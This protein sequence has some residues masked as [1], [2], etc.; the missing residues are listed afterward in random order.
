[1]LPGSSSNC[2]HG[3][4]NSLGCAGEGG[5]GGTGGVSAHA[6][7]RASHSL[8]QP[9]NHPGQLPN[10][11]VCSPPRLCENALRERLGM[12]KLAGAQAVMA[13]MSGATP[14]IAIIRFRL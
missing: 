5:S 9:R 1:L 8:G 3:D 13:W 2:L 12:G 11:M 4:A 10:R 6:F 7:P 14:R